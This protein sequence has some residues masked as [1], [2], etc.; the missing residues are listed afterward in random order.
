MIQ[1]LLNYGEETDYSQLLTTFFVKD[2]NDSPDDTDPKGN[3][4]GLLERSTYI[5]TS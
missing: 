2:D 5:E 3:T 1:T 4:A